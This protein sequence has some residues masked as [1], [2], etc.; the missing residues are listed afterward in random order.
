MACCFA[1]IIHIHVAI[2]GNTQPRVAVGWVSTKIL[3]PWFGVPSPTIYIFVAIGKH[4]TAGGRSLG[5]D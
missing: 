3:L 4:T 1:P 2:G 5:L